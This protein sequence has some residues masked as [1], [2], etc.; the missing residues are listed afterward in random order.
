[1]RSAANGTNTG[2]ATSYA[3]CYIA[4]V[5]DPLTPEAK[6]AF[7]E[8]ARRLGVPLDRSHRQWKSTGCPGDE[9]AAWVAAGAPGPAAPPPPPPSDID[10]AAV[11]RMAATALRGPLGDQPTIKASSPAL[12]IALLQQVLNLITNA[13]LQV[14]GIW[15]NATET[16]VRNFQKFFGLVDD[17]IFGPRSR[18]VAAVILDRI[19][20]GEL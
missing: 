3:T 7:L 19:K 9:L 15:G 18:F 10:W 8:E 1:M 6:A 11:R 5:G 16:A 2:N 17:G 14:D 20:A 12:R 13:G 4:G